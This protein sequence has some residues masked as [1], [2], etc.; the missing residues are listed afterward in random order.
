MSVCVENPICINR[1]DIPVVYSY[2]DGI[3]FVTHGDKW[4][5]HHLLGCICKHR[6]PTVRQ[7]DRHGVF[8]HKTMVGSIC[9]G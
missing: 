7:S 4:V 3:S 9:V 2:I 1:W 5:V 6:W 8:E